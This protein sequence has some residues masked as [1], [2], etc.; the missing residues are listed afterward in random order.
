MSMKKTIFTYMLFLTLSGVIITAVLSAVIPPPL[1]ILIAAAV[2]LFISALAY[3]ASGRLTKKIV[4]PLNCTDP[5]NT[6]EYPYDELSPFLRKVSRQNDRINAQSETLEERTSTILTITRDMREGLILLD[7]NGIILSANESAMNIFN[8]AIDDYMNRNILELTRRTDFLDMV[9]S[10]LKGEAGDITLEFSSRIIQIFYDPVRSGA[11]LLFLDITEKA[12]AEKLR[13]EFTANVSH[14]LKTPLTVISGLSEM[15]AIGM[16]KEE[17]TKGFANKIKTE[18]ER[19][20]GLVNDVLRLSELDE[21]SEYKQKELFNLRAA[22]ESAAGTLSSVSEEKNVAVNISGGE[23]EING[24]KNMITE[25]IS[26]LLDNAIKYN[27]ENGKAE[28]ILAKHESEVK[29]E[30][31][32]TGIGVSEEHISRMFERFYRVDKSRSKKTGGTG[33]GLAIVKHIARH[34]NGSVGI[35]STPGAGTKVTVIIKSSG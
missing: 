17:D 26:N 8:A 7:S 16:A 34:H 33:L 22:A 18:T 24:D 27:V 4:D 5:A 14:E 29:I 19:M 20:I 25:L 11:I 3:F 9:R 12:N 13:R 32:D 6:D 21:S 15:I 28:I 1:F 10:A 23:F 30:V 2:A 35:E 31:R